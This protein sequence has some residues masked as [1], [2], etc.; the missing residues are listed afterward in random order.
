MTPNPLAGVFLHWLGGL[1]SA[2]FYVPFRKVKHWS[3][4]VFW[5]T[6]G[7][8]SWLLAPWIFAFFR[9]ADLPGVLSATPGSVWFWCFF[10][11]LLWG[12]GGL[13]FGLTMRYLGLSLGMAIIMGLTATFGTL[14]PPLVSGELARLIPTTHGQIVLLGLA[15]CLAGITVVGRAG[16][17]KE[18]EM[19][20]EQQR[21][22]IAEFDLKKGVA[23]AIFSGIT[24]ACFAYGLA[25]GEPV[26]A[27][28]L[29]AG[30]APLWQ[31]LPVLCL[32][33]LGGATTNF[34]WCGIL[35]ARNRT[36][37]EFFGAPGPAVDGPAPPPLLRNYL[38]CALAGTAWYFQ[39]FFYTMG[40]SQMG[41]Y[42]FSSWTLHMAS[43]IIFS[44]L[45]G[46]A[47]KEWRGAS[48]KT[49]TLVFTGLALLVASTVIIGLGNAMG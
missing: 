44:S 33:L 21:A 22:A 32:V 4:E 18:G 42:G 37:G 34:I 11:G 23:V 15:V 30:T 13:T 9:T 1:A 39:F 48:R 36:L 20:L 2:S 17:L 28:T 24:S 49:L 8:F 19:P 14:M 26:K 5:L 10:F 47:L 41:A 6:G 45:W 29:A 31:G 25:A 38:L 7:I 16:R 3:W 12:L 40:E 27:L 46:F 43:I 35:I